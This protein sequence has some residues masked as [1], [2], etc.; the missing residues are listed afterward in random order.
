M[1]EWAT[2]RITI[3]MSDELYARFKAKCTEHSMSKTAKIL[4]MDW[5]DSDRVR[6]FDDSLY[7]GK[8]ICSS[9]TGA[10]SRS[11]GP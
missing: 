6:G 11:S 4:I 10:G 2:K 9:T 3:E 1:R 5:I 8:V 7:D